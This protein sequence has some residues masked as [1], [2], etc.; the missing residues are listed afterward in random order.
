MIAWF[1]LG[2]MSSLCVRKRYKIVAPAH[3]IATKKRFAFDSHHKW[4]AGMSG[5]I[6]MEP[7]MARNGKMPMPQ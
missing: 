5:N 2:P 7:R 3:N 4:V 1:K 6:A